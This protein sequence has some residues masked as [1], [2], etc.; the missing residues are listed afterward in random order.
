M[1]LIDGAAWDVRIWHKNRGQG[2]EGLRKYLIPTRALIAATALVAT[3]AVAATNVPLPRKRPDNAPKAAQATR[4]VTPNISAGERVHV[5][6][7]T[8]FAR[9]NRGS[10]APAS[11]VATVEGVDRAHGPVD[12]PQVDL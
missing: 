2:A 7:G 5:G 11:P 3:T 10:W 8:R 6:I 1:L 12:N 4:P 9:S